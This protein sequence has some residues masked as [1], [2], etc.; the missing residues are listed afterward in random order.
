MKI[1]QSVNQEMKK[2]L[3]LKFHLF[4]A[5]WIVDYVCIL[6]YCAV[7]FIERIAKMKFLVLLSILAESFSSQILIISGTSIVSV[8]SMKGKLLTKEWCTFP[9][10]N[11]RSKG[12]KTFSKQNAG[13]SIN[14]I[15]ESLWRFFK[16]FL[17]KIIRLWQF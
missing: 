1:K 8:K 5:W 14:K 17:Y 13:I 4:V 9:F 12:V 11:E 10:K 6:S 15:K 2:V 3:V 7:L 16:I